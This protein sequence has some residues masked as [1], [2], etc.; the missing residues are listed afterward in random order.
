MGMT[1]KE[2]DGQLL[3]VFKHVLTQLEHGALADVNHQTAVKI[4]TQGAKSE[5]N[6]QLDQRLSQWAVIGMCL[7][8]QG[9]DVIVNER[10]RE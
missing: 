8:H 6:T 10:S 7:A 1:V 5:N 9:G 4:G 2:F 3:H